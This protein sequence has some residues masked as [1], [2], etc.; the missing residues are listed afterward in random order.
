MASLLCVDDESMVLHQTKL[1]L[2]TAGHVVF[3]AATVAD[4]F[5]LIKAHH[6][7]LLL[8]DC[9][10]DRGWLTVEAKR[11]N[12]SV[13]VAIYT[14][15][16]ECRDLPWVDAVFHKPVSSP[17]LLRKISELLAALPAA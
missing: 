15:D 4:A 11:I 1:L 5:A 8:L 14:G 12:P 9:V 2:Q 17:V 3:T 10:P 16:T 6:F 7:D 13:R